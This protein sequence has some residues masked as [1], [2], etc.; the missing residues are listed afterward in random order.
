[1]TLRRAAPP[2][3]NTIT[4]ALQGL[5]E[6]LYNLFARRVDLLHHEL[7]DE[8]RAAVHHIAFILAGAA[9][10]I[11]GYALVLGALILLAYAL[12][13]RPWVAALVAA[14]LGGVHL[15]AGIAGVRRGM[16]RLTQHKFELEL[17]K[18]EF[19]RDRQWL[20]ELQTPDAAIPEATP[21]PTPATRP[22][23]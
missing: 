22:S 23:S 18:Q 4:Q 16:A 17:S 8:A 2:K 14:V 13:G 19:Q 9:V 12:S 20:H 11:F 1:M 7:V 3:D 6:G 10:A 5:S 15:G 21:H